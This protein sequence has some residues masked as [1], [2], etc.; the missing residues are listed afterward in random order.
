MRTKRIAGRLSLLLALAGMFF[1]LQGCTY[2]RHRGEDFADMFD[3]GF[4][5]TKTPQIGLYANGVSIICGG[6]S[7][8]DGWFAGWGGGQFGITRHYNECWGLGFV[9]HETIGW[10]D[11]DRDDPSTMYTQ[12]QGIG[13][14]FSMPQETNPAYVP[15][16]VHF[17]PHLGFVGLVW[18]L[19]YMEMVD[20]MAG[21]ANIDIAND[22]GVRFAS[23]D[24]TR[25]T[26]ASYS[27]WDSTY[28]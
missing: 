12:W 2:A 16:C 18:N 24:G 19:R 1:A 27:Y 26:P 25:T 23:W 9:G 28:R 13:G 11:F 6:Y 8:L 5:I 22:D 7:H 21:F 4:T 17:F 10:G 14:A 3:L 20:F 15:A